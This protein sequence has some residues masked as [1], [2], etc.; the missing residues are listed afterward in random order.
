MYP[1]ILEKNINLDKMPIFNHIQL[2]HYLPNPQVIMGPG[3]Y[4]PTKKV[5]I[6]SEALK[7]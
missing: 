5:I 2:K 6:N 1:G 4:P 7:A 3:N